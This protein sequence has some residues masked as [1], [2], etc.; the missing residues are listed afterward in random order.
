MSVFSDYFTS[1]K[2]SRNLTAN[3]IADMCGKD[4]SLVFRWLSGKRIPAE[5][6]QME[7]ITDRLQMFEDEI[8]KLKNAYERTLL[9]EEAY[10]CHQKVTEIFRVL[11]QRR[12]EYLSFQE[13]NPFQTREVRLPEF[14][15][16]NNKMEILSWLQNVLDYLVTQQEKK[17]YL[18]MQSMPSEVLMLLKLF[19]SRTK[20]CEIE[21][22]VYL[23][24]GENISQIHN[25][26]M[27]K[28]ITEILVQKNPIEIYGREELNVQEGFSD[29]WILSE[30][31]MLQFDEELSSGMLSTDSEWIQF[32][33][34]AFE[35]MKH[36][37]KG[38]GK[39]ACE[40]EAFISTY[41]GEN[42]IGN[43]IEYMPCIG[44]SLT[45]EIL[46]R[47]IY[48][49]IPGREML[50]QSILMNYEAL[51]GE[52]NI[53][54][55]SFFFREGLLE[56][57]DTGRIENFPYMVYERPDLDIR[58]Q[59]LQNMIHVSENGKNVYYMMKD[60]KLPLM[61]NLYV[62]QKSGVH[63]SLN[64]D[65]HLEE[66]TKERFVMQDEG[67]RKQFEEFFEH[68]VKGGYAYDAKETIDY[69]KQV[70]E[71]YKSKLNE[72]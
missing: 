64:I 18:K 60:G 40:P 68:L 15:K 63:G 29:N 3:Q 13:E 16:L 67:L 46:E 42:F 8:S 31:F 45:R 5:W 72:V 4:V 52:R 32:S 14:V 61:R 37:G 41:E 12:D 20:D 44:C 11:Q 48:P 30:D 33:L 9:G 27:L 35:K 65:M 17:L 24:N 70:L 51:N 53:D 34:Q 7:L 50:I 59:L 57:M 58:C 23:K 21:A 6:K 49:Q 38:F 43:S 69:M 26:E 71:Q 28:G 2:E 10:A 66:G 19:C 25:L 1:I 54:W 22:I 55:K 36:S 47:Q 56:F 62:E 39:K